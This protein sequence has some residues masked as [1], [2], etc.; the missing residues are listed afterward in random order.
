M[1]DFWVEYFFIRVLYLFFD[2]APNYQTSLPLKIGGLAQKSE[3]L[4]MQLFH[5]FQEVILFE[6][7]LY[8]KYGYTDILLLLE[9]QTCFVGL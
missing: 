3:D 7:I 1:F 5:R 4:K 8:N 9:I 6:M 2:R